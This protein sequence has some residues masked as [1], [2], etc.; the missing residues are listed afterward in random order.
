MINVHYKLPL[1]AAECSVAIWHA[2]DIPN[3]RV[4][5]L[6][7]ERRWFA[8]PSSAVSS[9]ILFYPVGV[10]SRIFPT[11]GRRLGTNAPRSDSTSHPHNAQGRH[12]FQH[13]GGP[14]VACFNFFSNSL[15]VVAP[16]RV[17]SLFA[18]H[19]VQTSHSSIQHLRNW[20]WKL[21]DVFDKTTCYYHTE[22][23]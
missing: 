20:H 15:V 14:G 1:L 22:L 5:R 17:S 18:R 2:R 11:L 4:K 3:G 9:D 21:E 6:A 23:Y 19:K 13:G 10:S 8:S 16:A 12:F 7:K